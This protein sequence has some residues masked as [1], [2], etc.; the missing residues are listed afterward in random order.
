[1]GIGIGI[2]IR[3]GIGIGIGIAAPG[4]A[5]GMEGAL[6]SALQPCQELLLG[7]RDGMLESCLNQCLCL[8]SAREDKQSNYNAEAQSVYY[9]GARLSCLFFFRKQKKNLCFHFA[10]SPP[11]TQLDVEQVC[12]LNGR[13]EIL[14]AL[15]W[16]CGTGSVP[17]PACTELSPLQGA[18]PAVE[19]TARG[20]LSRMLQCFTS[21]VDARRKGRAVC[22]PWLPAWRVQHR[23]GPGGG[24]EQGGGWRSCR[25]FPGRS[26]VRAEP[27]LLLTA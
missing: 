11:G 3:I 22:G 19:G 1:M 5:W 24:F 2:G 6:S 8:I 4:A 26:R 17:F 7:L 20:D 23:F 25:G 18:E 21:P 16:L 13:S 9:C 12:S 27:A 14:H 15:C 10:A